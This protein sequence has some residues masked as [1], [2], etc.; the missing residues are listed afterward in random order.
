MILHSRWLTARGL[1]EPD[2]LLDDVPATLV[3][4]ELEVGLLLRLSTG[5]VIWVDRLVLEVRVELVDPL[6]EDSEQHDRV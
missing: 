4:L 3:E 6:L 2:T 5:R 1:R